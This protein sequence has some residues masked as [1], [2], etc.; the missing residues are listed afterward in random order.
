ME[1]S[2]K[3]KGLKKLVCNSEKLFEEF[4]NQ[5]IVAG[6]MTRIKQLSIIDSLLDIKNFQAPRLHKLHKP[7]QWS[8]SVDVCN[9]RLWV[10][11]CFD[12]LD[13]EWVKS[14]W[15]VD[16]EAWLDSIQHIKIIFVGDNHW[17]I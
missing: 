14:E 11:I 16:D 8:Y 7:M 1:I 15:D 13:S 10:R 6:V 4:N 3:S 5:K 2:Y 12:C 9:K 17:L